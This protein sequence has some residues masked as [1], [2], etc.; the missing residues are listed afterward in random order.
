VCVRVQVLANIFNTSSARCWSSDTYNPCPGVMEGVPA[1]RDFEGGFATAL[2]LKDLKL[3][4]AA[5]TAA[6]S[7]VPIGDKAH[8]IFGDVAGNGW[9]GKDFGSVYRWLEAGAPQ[10]P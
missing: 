5:A 8:D 1:S 6:E 9:E 7:P 4:L 10:K 2:M 3:A